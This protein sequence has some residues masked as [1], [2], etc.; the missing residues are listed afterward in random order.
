MIS[1]FN[2]FQGMNSAE[3]R[4]ISIL[5]DTLTTN[6]TVSGIWAFNTL[7]YKRVNKGSVSGNVSLN[8]SEANYFI[9]T[10]TANTTL[11]MSGTISGDVVVS[12]GILAR[13]GASLCV[14]FIL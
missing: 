2:S 1:P 10:P 12:L 13:L 5:P 8:I 6:K 14:E 7:A 11:A 9:L 4:F 3:K